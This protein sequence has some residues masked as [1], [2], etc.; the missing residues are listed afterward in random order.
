M[1]DKNGREI[2]YMRI[3]VTDR[4]NLR[5]IYCMP[6][7]GVCHMQHEQILSYEE[8]LRVIRIMAGL[9]IKYLRLTG[10]EPMVRKGCLDLAKRLKG[11]EGIESISM[12]TNGILLK[13]RVHEVKQ[14]GISSLNISIDALDPAVY[15]GLT[16][17][18]DLS[19]VLC[20]LR[21][22]LDE[23]LNVKI[24]T[25]PVRG[26]N[27]EE[28]TA[29]ARLAREEPIHVRF[30]ELMP[31]GCGGQIERISSAEVMEKLEAVF[32]KPAEDKEL[33]GYGPAHYVKYPGFKGSIGFISAVSHEFCEN[34]NRV[35]LTADGQ[36]KL[37]LN[38]TK[39]LDLREMLRNGR[40]DKEI[41][42]AVGRA[43]ADKPVRH[44]FYEP[45][46]DQEKR[47]MNQIGG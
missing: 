41:L 7:N 14:A 47:C 26:I 42:E 40:D 9:G 37:C 24:N 4:C 29:I 1:L 13:D 10:G 20:V 22:A 23:G 17:G 27:E 44:A 36:L 25:V 32:G 33:H 35:R 11:T 6:E 38:H 30:I 34:C 28:L 12:T 16:R 45:I 3:S 15:E 39:G 46:S 5:C 19:Q 21:Q 2:D 31:V 18:G 43:I 8:I